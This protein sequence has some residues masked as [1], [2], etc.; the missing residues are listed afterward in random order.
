MDSLKATMGL[1]PVRNDDGTYGPSKASLAM[2]VKSTS[3][4]QARTY[5]EANRASGQRV[6]VLCT[7]DGELTCA[8]GKTMRTG[9]HP[10]ELFVVLLH[11]EQAGFALDLVTLSGK[12]VPIETFAVPHKDQD[13]LDIM[14]RFAGRLRAPLALPEVLAGLKDDSPYAAIYVPGGHGAVLGLPDSAEAGRLLRWFVEHGK[15]IITICHGPAALLALTQAQPAEAFPFKGYKM[16]AFPDSG[17][18]LMAGLGY[19]PGAMPWFFGEKLA[20]LGLSNVAKLPIGV[21][22][23]DRKL[24]SG[25]SPMAADKLGR[26]AAQALLAALPPQAY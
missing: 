14:Q 2:A 10:V 15:H 23:V 12:P 18:R 19:L 25:D 3:G 5:P 13:V 24:I 7:E 26:L 20:Q 22:H 16:A 1:A 17:D 9:N 21:T 4:Y 11:L 8:N 6:L